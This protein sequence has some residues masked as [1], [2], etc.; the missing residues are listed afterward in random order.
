MKSAVTTRKKRLD[1][2]EMS[3]QVEQL[4]RRMMPELIK[5]KPDDMLPS[6]NE[7]TK[8]YTF[9]RAVIRNF[10]RQLQQEGL[11]CS[12][13]CKGFFL[14]DKFQVKDPNIHKYDLSIGIVA[15]VEHGNP[16]TPNSSAAALLSSFESQAAKFRS[17][18]KLYNLWPDMTVSLDMLEQISVDNPDGIL[19]HYHSDSCSDDDIRKLKLLN[20]PMVITGFESKDVNSIVFDH[21]QITS[22]AVEHLIERGHR[23]LGFIQ[24]SDR[25]FFWIKE[26]LEGVKKTVAQSGVECICWSIS[27]PPSSDVTITHI[28]EKIVPELIEK[29]I[30]GVVCSG[31]IYASILIDV[32]NEMG[33]KVPDDVAIVGVDDIWGLRH[34]DLTTV[35]LRPGRFGDAAYD[36]LAD[37]IHHNIPSPTMRKITCPLIVRSTT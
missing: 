24:R 4:R 16:E 34:Y 29:K 17:R 19:L 32:F 2:R 25:N 6:E 10:Y 30:S 35:Q 23:N 18:T 7:L 20:I 33:I 5:L 9:S 11:V 3:R 22:S 36:L 1:P 28:K 27:S 15:Y 12:H 14:T 31:D 8:R 13:Q 21:E 26:R 37:I